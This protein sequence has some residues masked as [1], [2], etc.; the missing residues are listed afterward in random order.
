V[1][2]NGKIARLPREIREALNEK[3]DENEPGPAI[4]DWLNV[5]P[6]VRKALEGGFEAQQVSPANLSEWRRGRL[7]GLGSKKGRRKRHSG[8]TGGRA[9][10]RRRSREEP[11]AAKYE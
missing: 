10:R 8:D 6:E 1:S 3:L 7:R 11:A 9:G 2:G 5:M 4:L